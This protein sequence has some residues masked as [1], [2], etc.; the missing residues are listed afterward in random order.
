MKSQGIHPMYKRANGFKRILAFLFDIIPIWLFTLLLYKIIT[1][2][3]PMIVNPGARMT[4]GQIWIKDAWVPIWILY[5]SIMECTP[6]RGTLG[7]KYMGL[8]VLGPGRRPLRLGRALSRNFAKILSF[9]PCSLGFFWAL[10][11][12]NSKAWH[13]SMSGCGVYEKR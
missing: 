5:C 12:K 6:L 3:S 9:I 4:H 11:S 1:D 7:K 13:D 10:F 2:Q 8:E